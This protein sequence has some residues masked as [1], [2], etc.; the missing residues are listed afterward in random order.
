MKSMFGHSSELHHSGFGISP[1]TFDAIDV[2]LALRKLIFTMVK[3]IMLFVAQIDK[4]VVAF[5]LVGVNGA[6]HID[7]ALDNGLERGSA[8]IGYNLGINFIVAF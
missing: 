8:D 6:F 7:L 5:P 1:E 2:R 3:L 4:S